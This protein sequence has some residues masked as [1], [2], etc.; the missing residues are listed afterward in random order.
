[1]MTNIDSKINQV[2]INLKIL[3]NIKEYD[4]LL[5]SESDIIEIDGAS[6]LQPVKRWWNGRNRQSTLDFLKEFISDTFKIID[7]TLENELRGR[8]D[9]NF[10]RE[11]NHNILQKFLLELTNSIRGLQ[12]LKITY[13]YDITFKSQ[14]DILIEGIEFRNERIREALKITLG[15][16]NPIICG[17]SV[18]SE[19]SLK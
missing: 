15:R 2:F 17:S 3:S 9:P 12:N 6:Y 16:Q 14:L 5:K 4:K 19:A 8:A 18:R 11:S 1:M 13:S 7:D 10:F